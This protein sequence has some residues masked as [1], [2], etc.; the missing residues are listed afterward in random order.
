VKE[1]A[2]NQPE[3]QH[4]ATNPSG[5]ASPLPPDRSSW[6]TRLGRLSEEGDDV[7]A[8]ALTPAERIEMMWPLAVNAWAFIGEDVSGSQFQRH[9]VR[10]ERRRG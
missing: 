10:I 4:V 6:P 8:L 9:V 3:A 5:G 1:I 2:M 7:D